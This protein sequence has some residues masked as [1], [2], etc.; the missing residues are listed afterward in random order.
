MRVSRAVTAVL[1]VLLLALGVGVV[2]A[3]GGEDTATPEDVYQ[4][5]E[6]AQEAEDMETI[7]SLLASSVRWTIDGSK[8]GMPDLAFGGKTQVCETI[9]SGFAEEGTRTIESVDVSGDV[10]NVS[11]TWTPEG[12]TMT[13]THTE[14]YTVE[15]G[16]ITNWHVIRE[17]ITETS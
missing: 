7:E 15:D 4:Q 9:E 13:L 6:A 8:V 5:F 3:C 16:L 14:Q 2:V 1:A 17:E 10:V 12:A 11:S